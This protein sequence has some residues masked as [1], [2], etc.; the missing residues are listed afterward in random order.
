MV[1]VTAPLKAISILVV[2]RPPSSRDVHFDVFDES[3]DPDD[4]S[5][6]STEPDFGAFRFPAV[7][8]SG[9]TPFHRSSSMPFGRNPDL[10]GEPH[11]LQVQK[12]FMINF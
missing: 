5:S 2:S 12:S 8:S 7:G 4:A 1:R 3:E 10:F 6:Q 9:P 11:S